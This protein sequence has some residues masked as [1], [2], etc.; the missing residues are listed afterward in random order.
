MSWV[1]EC[2]GCGSVWPIRDVAA[3]WCPRCNGRL[4]APQRAAEQNPPQR[5]FAHRWVAHPAP[6]EIK[7]Q[8]TPRKPSRLPPTPRMNINPGWSLY[9]D[10]VPQRPKEPRTRVWGSYAASFLMV[11]V[12]LYLGAGLAELV[13]YGVLLYNRTRLVSPAVVYASDFLV[14]VTFLAAVMCAVLAAVSAACWLVDFRREWFARLGRRDTRSVREQLLGYLLP[15]V[16]LWYPA[17]RMTEMLTDQR[18]ADAYGDR[19]EPV[20]LKVRVWWTLWA[21]TWACQLL[22]LVWRQTAD[23]IQAQANGVQFAVLTHVLAAGC[24]LMTLIVMREFVQL[25]ENTRQRSL[26]RWVIAT[27]T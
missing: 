6:L 23:T 1:Q 10:Y 13:R 2:T 27:P 9:Q 16:T 22:S 25:R 20:L 21:A 7:G 12:G 5:P 19:R 8:R 11:A 24:A 3:M 17:T 4:A 14:A 26:K 15:I 18:A